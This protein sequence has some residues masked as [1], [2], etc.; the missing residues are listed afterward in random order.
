MFVLENANRENSVAIN[1]GK[2]ALFRVTCSPRDNRGIN[3][4]LQI[5]HA[6]M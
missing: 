3:I 4:P 2:P 6:N 1:G 5:R